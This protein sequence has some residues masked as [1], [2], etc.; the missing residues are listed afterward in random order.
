MQV[1]KSVVRAAKN[2]GYSDVES[3][4]RDA[5]SN[6]ISFASMEQLNELASWSFNHD[7]AVEIVTLLDKRL[8][9]K[10]KSWRHVYK[11]L[12]LIDH[13]VHYGS[14]SVVRY[15]R[16]NLYIIK[17]LQEFQH[18]EDDGVDVGH[19]VRDKARQLSALLLDEDRL[20][21]ERGNGGKS[22]YDANSLSRHMAD[23]AGSSPSSST[24]R[25][26][27]R[28]QTM[29]TQPT[30]A[31]TTR[32]LRDQR[33]EKERQEM[34]K[35][36][37]A[38]K[39]DEEKRQRLLKEQAGDGLFGDFAANPKD[40]SALVSL[41]ST[42]SIPAPQDPMQQLYEE[43]LRQQ[44]AMQQAQQDAFYYQ[45]SLALAQQQQQQA[46]YLDAMQQ[47]A[48]FEQLQA[49]AQAQYAAQLQQQQQQQYYIQPQPTFSPVTAIGQN[50]PF[51]AFAS[52]PSS[53]FT[54]S[55]TASSF[56][57]SPSLS[58]S[59]P[60]TYSPSSYTCSSLAPPPIATPGRPRA[61]TTGHMDEQHSQLAALVGQGGGVDTFGN[62]GEMRMPSG[63][64]FASFQGSH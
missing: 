27:P 60:S 44:A 26:R 63:S 38:S 52:S 15:F 46:Q 3:R 53:S 11:S 13:L 48:A 21:R 40:D 39:E 34:G 41:A 1:G 20:R 32:R 22:I 8:N 7:D 55:S 4:V 61:S 43:Q 12:I 33:R 31:E 59:P 24:T 49:Q 23:S 50:N 9:D 54:P 2:L 16:N 28:S 6:S 45:Q 10:G 42:A 62:I 35:A 19:N 5:T 18:N 47:Q 25:P 14:Y 56:S 57:P 64:P 17:T 51:A 30:S 29:P 58:T 36:M 37:R